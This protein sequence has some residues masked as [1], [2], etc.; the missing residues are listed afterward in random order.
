MR[1]GFGT[2]DLSP[3]GLTEPAQGAGGR[4]AMCLHWNGGWRAGRFR[5]SS[6][7]Y[8]YA[9]AAADRPFPAADLAREPAPETGFAGGPGAAPDSGALFGNSTI[10]A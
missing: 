6:C 3:S 10:R 4:A 1:N 8:P 5:F 7:G 2:I 9:P